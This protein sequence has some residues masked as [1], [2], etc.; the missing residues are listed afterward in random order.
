LDTV[1]FALKGGENGP[2]IKPGNS[3]DSLLIQVV[4]GTHP[5]IAAMPYKKP[6]L[7]EAQI[8]LLSDWIDQ[9][10]KAIENERPESSKHWSFTA[11]V[12]PAIPSIAHGDWA[13]INP[14]D[15]FICARLE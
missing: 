10:P 15:N 4:K 12:R 11:P 13:I 6:R 9:G 5:Q 8:A 1:A 2:S 3:A 14:I 7:S